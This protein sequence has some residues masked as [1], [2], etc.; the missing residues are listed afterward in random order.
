MSEA[1][2][3][4]RIAQHLHPMRRK[5]LVEIA[6]GKSCKCMEIEGPRGKL[7]APKTAEYH[8]RKLEEEV[9]L[10]SDAELTKLALRLGLTEIDV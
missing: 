8:R 1:S 4:I 2:L 6:N 7:I 3:K 9:D 5:V 10:W